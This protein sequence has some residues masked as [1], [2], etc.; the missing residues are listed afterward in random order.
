M[1]KDALEWENKYSDLYYVVHFHRFMC[2]VCVFNRFLDFMKNWTRDSKPFFMDVAYFSERSV[3][4]E[5]D[6]ESHSDVTTIAM[7]YLVMFLYI[8]FT[9]GWNKIILSFFGIVIVI[10]SVVC[11]VGFYG[12]IGLPLSL[13]VLEVIFYYTSIHIYILY[14]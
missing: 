1:L 4:D 2:K 3:E 12:L 6:R 8:V 7:S 9:L 11:S 10:S 5:L 13:I 14:T